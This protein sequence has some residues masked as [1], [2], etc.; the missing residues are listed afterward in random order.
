MPQIEQILTTYAS[1]IFWLL[2]VFGL[3]YLTIGR[4]ML[5]KIESTV[6]DRNN[7]IAGDLAAAEA[8]RR[9]ADELEEAQR[10]RLEANRAE[11]LKVTQAAKDA[12][13]REAEAKLK[14]ADADIARRS[15]EAEA[16]LREATQSA[17]SEIETVAAEAARDLVARLSGVSVSEAEAAAAVKKALDEK[18]SAHG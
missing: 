5:P 16:R 10:V 14:A 9:A 11:A 8:A 4:G 15:D 17:L 2:I 13:A 6:D 12:S 1:Q 7:R 18:A 3:V